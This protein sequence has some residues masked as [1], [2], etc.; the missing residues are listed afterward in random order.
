MSDRV[1]IEPSQKR[2]RVSPGGR[3]VADS[4]SV[5][6]VWETPYYPTDYFPTGDVDMDLL[7]AIGETTR[8][9]S[10]GPGHLC[11]VKVNGAEAAGAARIHSESPVEELP[12]LVTLDWAAM[13]S[14]FEE[15]EQVYVHARDPYTRVDILSS[16]RAV[17][18]ESESNAPR[19]SSADPESPPG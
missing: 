11:T 5:R 15:D 17:R 1:R 7:I 9:P 6:L 4:T 12:D 10:R 18:V 16:S 8:S 3:A 19:P 13:D 2:V 14:W